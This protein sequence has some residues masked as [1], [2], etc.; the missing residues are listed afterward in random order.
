MAA[1]L[2]LLLLASPATGNM[3]D[4]IEDR[5]LP[6]SECAHGCASWSE[7]GD[8]ADWNGG[9][10]PA[11]AGRSCAHGGDAHCLECIA[12][13]KCEQYKNGEARCDQ[14]ACMR[15]RDG[16]LAPH[17]MVDGGNATRP[18]ELPLYIMGEPGEFC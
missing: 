5:K 13:P 6:P 7:L 16:Y 9:V 8:T 12:H 10:V 1:L 11:N 14:H 15:C 2:P 18:S 3:H 4:V 17:R